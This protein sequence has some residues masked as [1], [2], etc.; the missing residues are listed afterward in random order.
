MNFTKSLTYRIGAGKAI[1]LFFGLLGFVL[2]PMLVE[3]SS[4]LLRVG[5][6]F[7][8]ATLGA[9]IGVFGVYTRHP[10]L[11]LPLPWWVRG[12]ILGGWMNFL[13]TLI[14]YD[15]IDAVMVAMFGAYDLALSP[16]WMII[17]GAII[18]MIMD[19]ILTRYFGEFDY[20]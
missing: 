2:L 15:Q 11:N 1:G 8:Y 16:F 4:M 14:A 6:L 13:L 9:I 3:G 10:I 7:W 17:E 12:A 19:Y 18:G 20:G 5:I